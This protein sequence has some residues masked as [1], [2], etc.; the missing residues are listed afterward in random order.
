MS[1]PISA[2][3]GR[4]RI[5]MGFPMARKNYDPPQLAAPEP[6]QD[7]PGTWETFRAARENTVTLFP[8]KAYRELI[9][10]RNIGGRIFLLV[11]DPDC[12]GD[13]LLKRSQNYPKGQ[14]GL[15]LLG[16][17]LGRGIFTSD[18][19]DWKR[20]RHAAAPAFQFK[21]LVEFVPALADETRGLTERWAAIGS[22]RNADVQVD[23][24][25]EMMDLTLR[26]ICRTMFSSTDA[27][28]TE[29]V[30][31]ALELYL[32]TAGRLSLHTFLRLPEWVPNPALWR[33]RPATSYLRQLVRRVITQRRKSGEQ[34]GDLL[35]MLLTARDEDGREGMSE[36][37]LEDNLITFLAAGHETTANALTWAFYLLSLHPEVAVRVANEV[38]EVCGI[39]DPDCRQLQGP[40]IHPHG[41][42]RGDAALPARAGD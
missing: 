42:R 25:A 6:R 33:A 17:A 15:R 27:A 2:V 22:R 24:N 18:G 20:Q 21:R 7:W 30:A 28:E 5:A 41:D 10:A 12:V 32:S 36:V 40:H 34:K 31:S 14:T 11:N 8:D 1:G 26:I 39:G 35:D 38:W 3:Q 16:P 4:R 9:V 13:V 37:E 19:T 29:D 23:V